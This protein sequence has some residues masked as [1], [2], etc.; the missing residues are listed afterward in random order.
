MLRTNKFLTTL[1]LDYNCKEA[2]RQTIAIG[3]K[4]NSTLA[5]LKLSNN[6]ITEYGAAPMLAILY[7]A[8]GGLELLDFKGNDISKEM[9]AQLS[10]AARVLCALK[11]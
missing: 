7:K 9:K 11:I 3:L 4:D 5:S 2:G 8:G 1:F 10:S 6:Q